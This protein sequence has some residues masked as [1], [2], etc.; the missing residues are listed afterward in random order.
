MF[1]TGIST[2][3]VIF[4]WMIAM[5]EKLVIYGLDGLVVTEKVEAETEEEARKEIS[6]VVKDARLEIHEVMDA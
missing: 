2:S 5:S 3:W 6:R 1:G 4:I